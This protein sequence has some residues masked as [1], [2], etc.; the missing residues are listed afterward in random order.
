MLADPDLVRFLADTKER[1]GRFAAPSLAGAIHH[2][3]IIDNTPNDDFTI[4]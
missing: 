4:S 1:A 2:L 3:M